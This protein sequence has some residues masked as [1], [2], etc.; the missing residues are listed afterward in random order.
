MDAG[1]PQESSG[2]QARILLSIVGVVLLLVVGV[3]GG[4]EWTLRRE[5]ASSV[6]ADLDGAAQ[7]LAA[8]LRQARE[9]LTTEARVVAEEPRLKAALTT[10]GMDR[11]TPDDMAGEVRQTTHWDLFVLLGKNGEVLALSGASSAEGMANAGDHWRSGNVVYRL[12]R[13]KV[14]FGSQIFATLIAGERVSDERIAEVSQGTKTHAVVFAGADLVAVSF[15]TGGPLRAAAGSLATSAG[16][17]VELA[18]ERFL[19][20]VVPLAEA[21]K[22]ARSSCAPPTPRSRPTTACATPSSS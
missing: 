22:C 9:R 19:A 8:R 11:A 5:L 18:G 4:I 15:P 3:V 20:R 2:Y 16:G 13:A 1:P 6:V 14:A 21:R 10:E 17:E 12:G 7:A